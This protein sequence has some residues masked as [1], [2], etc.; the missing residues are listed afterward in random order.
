VVNREVHSRGRRRE[1]VPI[2]ISILAGGLSSR[3]GREKARLRLG[4]QTLIGRIRRMA[5]TLGLPVRVIRRDLVARCGP[6]GG[7]L[8]S[9]KTS[10]AKAEL[11]LAC[12]MPFV[13]ASRLERMIRGFNAQHRAVF[14]TSDDGVGFPFLLER[15]VLPL[16]EHQI[17]AGRYSLQSLA[18]LAG[19]RRLPV[20]PSSKWELFNVNTMADWEAARALFNGRASTLERVGEVRNPIRVRRDRK[21]HGR[22]RL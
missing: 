2:A 7:I 10:R 15:G 6:L 11:F 14:A 20:S 22:H 4:G 21:N 1:E 8:T 9:L 16:V 13:R 3:M 19:G 12:D 17:H 5:E 18:A